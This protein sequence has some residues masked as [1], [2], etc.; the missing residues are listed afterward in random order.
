MEITMRINLS[1]KVIKK[2]EASD[3]TKV[4][5]EDSKE[6]EAEDFDQ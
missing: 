2:M 3:E 1:R 4:P 6:E 5:E